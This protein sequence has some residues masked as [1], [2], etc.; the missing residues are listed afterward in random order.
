MGNELG[1]PNAGLSITE[2]K[3]TH[4]DSIKQMEEK[5][6]GVVSS[7]ILAS[8]PGKRPLHLIRIGKDPESKMGTNP[9]VFVGANF[10]GNRHWQQREPSFWLN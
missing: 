6:P 4:G 5:N 7:S 1:T 10:E 2:F 8:S 9:S 3:H